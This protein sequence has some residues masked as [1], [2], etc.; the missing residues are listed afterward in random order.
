[1]KN[2]VLVFFALFLV[3]STAFA[4]KGVELQ[5][6]VKEGAK[7]DI[8][9]MVVLDN[10]LKMEIMNDSDDKDFM[11][12]DGQKMCTIDNKRN[13]CSCMKKE[14]FKKLAGEI[15]K[16]FAKFDIEEMLKDVPPAQREFVRQQME[17]AM[18]KKTAPA[19][20]SKPDLKKIGNEKYNNYSSRK[21]ILKSGGEETYLWVTDWGNIQGGKEIANA[22]VNLGIF[23]DE[24]LETMSQFPG[25]QQREQDNFI[26]IMDDVNGVIH[27]SKAYENG[28]LKRES[29][30]INSSSREVQPGEFKSPYS[31]KNPLSEL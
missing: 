16:Q 11:T 23:F 9:K 8:T 3:Q 12:F 28:K 25:A 15:N 21:Y 20:V 4:K 6:E 26:R 18:P 30:L 10:N 31:C 22:F 7:T 5:M 29:K 1:M 17:K 19:A 2:L 27:S 13:E 24:M 14:D